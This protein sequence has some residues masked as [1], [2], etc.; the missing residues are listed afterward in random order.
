MR[1]RPLGAWSGGVAFRHERS[2]MWDLL[3]GLADPN[4][5]RASSAVAQKQLER[6]QSESPASEHEAARGN[7]ELTGVA[8]RVETTCTM[9]RHDSLLTQPNRVAFIGATLERGRVRRVD[10]VQEHRPISELEHDRRPPTRCV[11]VRTHSISRIG[12]AP[13]VVML[14]ADREVAT[15][16]RT[17]C[18]SIERYAQLKASTRCVHRVCR[19]GADAWRTRQLTVYR[20]RLRTDA[21]LHGGAAEHRQQEGATGCIACHL[22]DAMGPRDNS[23]ALSDAQ[24]VS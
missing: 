8:R 12:A 3:R 16:D 18:R 14:W 22:C 9:I 5:R 23:R 2:R 13:D 21:R 17:G 10:V 24:K 19:D 1:A 4:A 15:R 7:D 6:G 11:H 20:R